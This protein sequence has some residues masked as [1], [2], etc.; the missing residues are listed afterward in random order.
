MESTADQYSELKVFCYAPAVLFYTHCASFN[1]PIITASSAAVE[2]FRF[3]TTVT[4]N[5]SDVFNLLD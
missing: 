3:A 5:Q 2:R 4:I 1:L